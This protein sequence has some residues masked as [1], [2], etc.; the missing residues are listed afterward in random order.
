M[1]DA[2]TP[3]A[4][5]PSPFATPDPSA[6]AEPT[7]ETA[8]PPAQDPS[9]W[10]PP[11]PGT[12][13]QQQTPQPQYYG[14]QSQYGQYPQYPQYPQYGGGYAGYAGYQTPAKT[15]GMAIASLVLSLVWLCGIGSILAV[16]FGYMGKKQIDRSGGAETGRGIA[17]AGIVIGWIGVAFLALFI[18]LAIIGAITDSGTS[19]QLR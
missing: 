18:V 8:T 1:S 2:P 19:S 10:P 12:Q 15:N 14:G 17:I 9:Q 6:P 7:D 4:P 5:D 16:V 3:A 13:W 11:A